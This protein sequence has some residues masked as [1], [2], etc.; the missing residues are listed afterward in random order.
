[1]APSLFAPI[2]FM[3]T[4][5]LRVVSR[6]FCPKKWNLEVQWK[7]DKIVHVD[8]ME[9]PTENEVRVDESTVAENGVNEDG[10]DVEGT[11]S[12]VPGGGDGV[13]GSGEGLAGSS[14]GVAGSGVTR[15]GGEGCG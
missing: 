1:M 6:V 15:D 11:G 4:G 12:G 9:E 8:E 7:L 3:V 2:I 14:D 10:K 13:G 5:G